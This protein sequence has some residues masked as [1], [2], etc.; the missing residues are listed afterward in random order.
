[1]TRTYGKPA[2]AAARWMRLF[3]ELPG[4]IQ[5]IDYERLHL[6]MCQT[7]PT[8]EHD[9]AFD[10]LDE[11]RDLSSCFIRAKVAIGW[12]LFR[13]WLFVRVVGHTQ[14]DAARTWEVS[15]RTIQRRLGQV[16]NA[17]RDELVERDMTTGYAGRDMLEAGVTRMVREVRVW[18]SDDWDKEE[19]DG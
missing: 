15:V 5:G 4:Q 12:D 1:M 2:S 16:D 13:L 8:A 17:V 7:S 10:K 18:L 11:F 9:A 14:K 6:A 3:G 19:P